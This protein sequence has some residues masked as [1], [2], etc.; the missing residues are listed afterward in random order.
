MCPYALLMVALL[1]AQV[2]EPD[3]LAFFLPGI[4][5]GLCIA[6]RKSTV[7]APGVRSMP[8]ACA[9]PGCSHRPTVPPACGG[10]RAQGRQGE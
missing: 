6:I 2:G 1:R 9:L 7:D 3:T 4:C 10:I 8:L 5:S